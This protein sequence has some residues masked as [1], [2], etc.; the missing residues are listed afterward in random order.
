MLVGYNRA[1]EY[2]M[3]GDDILAPEAER[4]GLINHAVPAA[5]LDERV[6]TFAHRLSKGASKSINFTKQLVNIGLRQAASSMLDAC[7]AY[8]AVTNITKDHAEG[9]RAFMEKR[10]PRFTGE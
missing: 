3:T 10:P 9:V 7:I 5:E 2:L 6:M 8:E 1:K 4:I